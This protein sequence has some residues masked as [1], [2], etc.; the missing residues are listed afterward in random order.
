MLKRDAIRRFV[1]VIPL[2]ARVFGIGGI[3]IAAPTIGAIAGIAAGTAL[4]WGVREAVRWLDHKHNQTATDKHTAIKRD[5]N[6]GKI[7]HYETYK[8]QTNP[9]DPNPWESEKRYDGQGKGHRNKELKEDI[10]T[11]HIH[12][13]KYPGKVRYPETWELPI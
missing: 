12:D 8:H 13:P 11:P 9:R 5:P 3:A 4:Y 10:N 2:I 6:T 1:V 7:T